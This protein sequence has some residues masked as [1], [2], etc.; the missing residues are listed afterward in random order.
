MSNPFT[1][2]NSNSLLSNTSSHM[3]SSAPTPAW[4]QDTNTN[5]NTPSGYVPPVATPI[6]GS[7]EINGNTPKPVNPEIPRMILLTRLVNLG[8]STLIIV[9]SFLSILTTQTITTGVLACYLMV[10]SCLL[11]CFETHLT[12]VSKFIA[13]NFGFMYNSF[14]RVLFMMFMGTILFSLS[15][16]GKIMGLVVIGNAIFNLLILWRHPGFDE[17]KR[18]DAQ[19]DIQ[20]YLAQNPAF[21][22]QFISL[23][24]Q[25]AASNPG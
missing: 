13:L 8:I 25:S 3:S 21:A 1:S 15:L 5:M 20:E 2:S 18:Q 17:A 22:S 10:F 24:V 7:E 19:K 9:I 23:G 6:N 11:C 4:L 12:Q 14:S 16:F